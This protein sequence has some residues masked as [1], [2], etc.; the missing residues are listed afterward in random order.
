MNISDNN[1]KDNKDVEGSPGVPCELI[2]SMQEVETHRIG[3]V[4]HA[5]LQVFE[6]PSGGAIADVNELLS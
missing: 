6:G 5:A 4:S 3:V 1:F 2:D